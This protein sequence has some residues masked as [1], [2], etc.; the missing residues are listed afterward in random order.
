MKLI[1]ITLP[2]RD[3]HAVADGWG[4]LLDVPV[5]HHGDT[6]TVTVGWS[7]VTFRPDPGFAASHHLAITVPDD[8]FDDSAGWITDR[9]PLLTD[10]D[11]V[12]RF[13]AASAWN[14]RNLYFAGPEES[15]LE[16]IARRDRDDPAEGRFGPQHLRGISEIGIAVE[17]PVPDAAAALATV[18]LHPYKN[19]PG[20]G[21]GAVGDVDGLLILVSPGRTWFP[22][23]D[24]RVGVVATQITATGGTPGTCPLSS[25]A[26]LHLIA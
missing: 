11:G 3:P 5:S 23:G 6:G 13:E 8:V 10:A 26:T 18:G 17:H 1:E 12:D 21:F 25:R 24:R 9:T 20:D 7:R 4:D 19:P 14:A 15:V 22:T 2:A 16:F